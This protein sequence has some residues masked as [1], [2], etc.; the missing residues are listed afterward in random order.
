MSLREIYG[1]HSE[2]LD[3]VVSEFST[4]LDG[5]VE[6]ARKALVKEMRAKV[7]VSSGMVESITSNRKWLSNLDKRFMELLEEQGYGKL[8]SSYVGSFNGQFEW[9]D[10][11]LAALSEDLDQPLRVQF[12]RADREHFAA[13][14]NGSEKQIIEVADRVAE[15]ARK[16]AEFSVGGSTVEELT[17]H[18]ADTL[19]I[20]VSQS[21]ALA[22]TAM[23]SFY[24]TIS[25]RGYQIIES[26][27]PGL[28]LQ[29]SY[30]GPL[31]KLNRPFCLKTERQSRNG[32]T[33]TR[34]QIN[35]M[36][37]GQLPNVFVTCGGY[38][39]RHQW[40]ISTKA[41]SEMERNPPKANDSKRS[42]SRGDVMQ[43]VRTHR[44]VN[45][46][47]TASAASNTPHP[48]AQIKAL[49]DQSHAAVKARRVS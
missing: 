16:Q 47:R 7:R 4:R 46:G 32:K 22:E 38:R 9:F 2:A 36:R 23:T 3:S 34:K 20:T 6:S 14:K 39:C 8:V 37:N 19:D 21:E 11:V 28:E 13:F 24:R 42:P 15:R 12:T 17:E 40:V 1:E 25:D 35:Q 27:R 18:L 45:A 29:Y 26:E 44:D 41:I 33:W 49:R 31:D 5:M 43:E 30:D 48:A 10:K